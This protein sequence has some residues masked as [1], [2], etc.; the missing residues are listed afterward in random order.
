MFRVFEPF[1]RFEAF[2]VPTGGS[3]L[4][5]EQTIGTPGTLGF[6]VGQFAGTLP[7]GFAAL[8]DHDVLTSA[9]YGNYQYADGSICCWIPRCYYRIAHPDNPTY[10]DY[11]VN[12]IDIKG[13]D[14]YA[15]EAAA[16]AD[17]Y[18]M[19][20]AF[21]DGGK[22][23][24]GFFVDK[25]MASPNGAGDAAISVANGVPL[26]LTDD[27][28]YTN[29]K[30]DLT[31]GL[32]GQ[33]HDAVFLSRA[34]GAGWHCVSIFQ[35]TVL[36]F[37]SLAHA[38]AAASDTY[39]AWYDA[40]GTTNFPKGCNN[41]ALGD[42]NDG[43]ISY[44]S[45]GDAGD[46]NKPKTGSAN[47]PAKVA[48]NG[49]ACGV[50]DL[51]GTLWEVPLGITTPGAAADSC[52]RISSGDVYVLKPSVALHDL[53]EGH[54]GTNDA[55]GDATHLAT[56]YDAKTGFL[57][58]GSVINWQYVG[59]GSNQV[60]AE[61]TSGD[62]YLATASGIAKATGYG[63]GTNLFGH[64]GNYRYNSE[65]LTPVSGGRWNAAADAGVFARAW[66]GSR[67]DSYDTIGFRAGA[68]F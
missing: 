20:R 4:R 11:G 39:C 37:L 15:T 40:G 55:W 59:N 26:S 57:P 28:N 13:V 22:V 41:D 47:L 53:T 8:P 7:A 62:A 9:D 58:W 46:A 65:N 14:T 56:L 35:Q 50:M 64:D 38:Q 67:T 27:N 5:A 66:N 43:S 12:S 31:L 33:L 60:F 21:I 48:H 30:D 3:T 17:G 49:Q 51:N 36:A 63:S 19:F 1:N 42:T 45:A 18:A 61:D 2:A 25:Y 44:V 32:S 68:A 23:K 10:A 54:N 24:R 16:N 29:T 34:R 6:G 52:E